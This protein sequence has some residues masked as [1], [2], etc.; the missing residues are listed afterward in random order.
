LDLSLIQSFN[1]E[2]SKIPEDITGFILEIDFVEGK[3]KFGF[4]SFPLKILKPF[5]I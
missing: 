3:I 5:P 2:S 4:S 1:K